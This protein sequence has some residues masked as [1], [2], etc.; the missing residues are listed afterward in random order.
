MSAEGGETILSL[1]E[2]RER[3]VKEGCLVK[4]LK[5]PSGAAIRTGDNVCDT[6]PSLC[7]G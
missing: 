1:A 5:G 6:T 3:T 2:V 7:P 4:H